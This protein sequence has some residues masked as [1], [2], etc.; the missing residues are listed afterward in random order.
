MH[1]E[2]HILA[3]RLLKELVAKEDS[4]SLATAYQ[5]AF[6]LESS[7][8]QEFVGKV[9]SELPDS[10]DENTSES[11][12]VA[13]STTATAGGDNVHNDDDATESSRLLQTTDSS[14]VVSSP[15]TKLFKSI[16][17]ILRGAKTIG[18]QLEFLYRNNKTD[19]TILNKLRD[20]LEPR[21][22]IFHSAVTFSAAFTNAGTTNDS[23]YK[24]NLEWLS[25]A[26]NWSK[27]C[28]TAA[29]GAIH[30]GN[31]KHGKDI[32]TMYL[33]SQNNAYGGAYAHGGALYAL[34][35]VYANH[36]VEIVDFMR[37]NFK[38]ATEE[39]VQHGAALGLG[40]SAMATAN[41]DI[42]EDIKTVLW[43]DS[44]I[45]GE[46]AGLS[47]GLV[48]LGSGNTECINVML[49]YAHDTTHEKIVRGLAM[50]MALIMFGRQSDANE[51][52][53]TLLE[54]ADPSLRYG[55]VFTIAL[56][57]CG[58]GSNQAIRQLLHVA[59]SD[60]NDDVRRAAVLSLGFILFRKP[61]TVPRMVELL[62]ESYN[63]HVRY[64]AAMALGIACAG[65][66]LDEA[67]DLL[68][69]M[70]KDP[71]DFVRQ[72]ASIALAMILVQQNDQLNPKVSSI[73]KAFEKSIGE[74]H[75]DAMAKFGSALALGIID[76]GGRNCTIGLQTQTGSLNVGG[77]V[78]MAI[79]CQYWYWFPLTHFLSLS[80]V[81]TGIIGLNEEL[82]VPDF[83]FTSNCKPSLFDYPPVVQESAEKAPEAVET[84][85]LST[86]AKARQR[87]KQKAAREAAANA[88]N[89][90]AMDI[91]QATPG[92]EAPVADG[93]KMEV[94]GEE[95]KTAEEG[96]KPKKKEKEP[97][98]Y[99][100]QNMS[101]VLPGQHKYI[102]FDKDSRY[103][104]VKKVWN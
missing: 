94:E 85:V 19:I 7:S 54:D 46:A 40:I 51:L 53:N 20:S 92:P 28:A 52:I 47:M 45:V 3:G 49:T 16:R 87:A 103:V 58:T 48:M 67:I 79:F 18:L 25:K 62:S 76:A 89:G 10:D 55:G 30:K 82:E 88:A 57:Y 24:D 37:T 63:P 74:K 14:S 81:P 96:E 31:L 68:E 64:G 66:G 29:L 21:S 26:V 23:F 34:G 4:K 43:A 13:G 102:S 95:G 33:P 98:S 1:L 22:S 93:D 71:T 35:L 75:E 6:D 91:E 2:D 9:I 77:I 38:G 61:G 60:V 17:Q 90:D 80:F 36:G 44:A 65:T 99:S 32:L 12:D 8:T 69:P 50:G 27:F 86:T 39:I 83:S 100:V 104:P 78:G 59:V 11:G 42:Y 97:S 101:R 15:H 70:L 41:L 5:I 56:A 84:A 72:G 73:R